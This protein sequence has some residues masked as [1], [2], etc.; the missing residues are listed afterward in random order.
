MSDSFSFPERESLCQK[1]AETV[2]VEF[3]GMEKASV[4]MGR[5]C[6]VTLTLHVKERYYVAQALKRTLAVLL[7]T[8]YPYSPNGFQDFLV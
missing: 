1:N 2:K 4:Q 7:E 5:I 6:S 8:A 3:Y